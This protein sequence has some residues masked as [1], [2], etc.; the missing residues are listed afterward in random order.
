[1]VWTGILRPFALL[2]G[3]DALRVCCADL[4]PPRGVLAAGVRLRRPD[5][6]GGRDGCFAAFC[7]IEKL[8]LSLGPLDLL[9]W[10]LLLAA[11]WLWCCLFVCLWRD[12]PSSIAS[13]AHPLH[14]MLLA[15]LRRHVDG[16]NGGTSWVRQRGGVGVF[17]CG[18]VV[19]C[20]SLCLCLCLLRRVGSGSLL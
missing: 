5:R 8:K 3:A 4:F 11:C 20:L 14:A 10:L 16:M 18:R 17:Q 15:V 2:L 12:V 9:W 19:E 6:C 1:V 7:G 13:T